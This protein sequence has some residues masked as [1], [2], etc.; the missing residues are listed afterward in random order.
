MMWWCLFTPETCEL[1]L[2]LVMVSPATRPDHR[3]TAPGYAADRGN[4]ARSVD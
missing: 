1:D 4:P 3:P 2:W